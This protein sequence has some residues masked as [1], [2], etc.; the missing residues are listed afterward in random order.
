[1]KVLLAS[2]WGPRLV[3]LLRQAAEEARKIGNEGL[4]SLAEQ[5]IKDLDAPDAAGQA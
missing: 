1:M 5:R 3:D 4:A 2:R